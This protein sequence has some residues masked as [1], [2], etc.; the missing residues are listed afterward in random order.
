VVPPTV[1]ASTGAALIPHLPT[2]GLQQAMLLG[3]YAILGASLVLSFLTI[4]LL[5]FR[6]IYV[7]QGPARMVPTLWLVLGPLGQ[8]VTAFGLLGPHAGELLKAPSGEGLEAFGVVYGLPVWGFAMA[9]LAI[10]ATITLRTMRR[11][12]LPF[13]LTW[14]SFTFPVGTVVT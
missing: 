4:A 9:W 5:W 6:L 2:A 11:G 8:S 1:S 3:C 14:W 10:A 13:S 12:G 7:D